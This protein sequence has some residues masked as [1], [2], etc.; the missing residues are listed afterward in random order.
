MKTYIGIGTDGRQ[1]GPVR[2]YVQLNDGEWEPLHHW[3]RH[4]ADGFQWGYGGSG[5]AD[6]A[7]SIL[8]DWLGYVPEPSLY[9]AFKRDYVA[10]WPMHEGECWRV[11]SDELM[12]WVLRYQA[13][14]PG[15]VGDPL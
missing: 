9:Q 1:A 15:R 5:P 2:A 3:F 12:L 10:G 8:R 7:R 6:L 14:V 11:G 13:H 4:S